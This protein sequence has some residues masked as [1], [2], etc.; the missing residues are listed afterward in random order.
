VV[1]SKWVHFVCE[2]LDLVR[3]DDDAAKRDAEAEE[4][5]RE[6]VGVPVLDLSREDLVTYDE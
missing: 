4:L 1:L 6:E 5:A 2:G 3:T